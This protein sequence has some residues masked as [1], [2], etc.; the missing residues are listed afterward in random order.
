MPFEIGI[1][2]IKQPVAGYP[3]GEC[4]RTSYACLLEL[5]LEAVPR[6][7]PGYL[8]TIGKEQRAAE[9][10]WLRSKGYDLVVVPHV[11]PVEGNEQLTIPNDLYHLM[12][13]L[14]RYNGKTLRH[15]VVGRG[16]KVVWDPHPHDNEIVGVEAY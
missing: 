15:R 8:K 5:P 11:G 3:N 9:R 7:D 16:G 2:Q 10:A 1:W 12:T 14:S 4:V 13:V 6:F